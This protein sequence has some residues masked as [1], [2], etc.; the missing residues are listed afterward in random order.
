MDPYRPLAWHIANADGLPLCGQKLT[1]GRRIQRSEGPAG[2]F[3]VCSRCESAQAGPKPKLRRF[4]RKEAVE[5]HRRAEQ[6]AEAAAEAARPAPMIVGSPK[7]PV[8]SIMG[9]PDGGLDP[10]Q[11]QYLVN[12]GACGMAWVVVTPGN[13]SFARQLRAYAIE[14]RLLGI[15][16]PSVHSHYYGGMEIYRPGFNGQSYDRGMAAARAYAEVLRAEGID[17]SPGGRLD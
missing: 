17:A 5:L 1:K 4:T 12:E 6:A 16:R 7:D 15:R 13:C 11:P 14:Q 9:L 2:H 3:R 8:A 10:D